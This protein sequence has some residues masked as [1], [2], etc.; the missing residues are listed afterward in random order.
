MNQDKLAAYQTLY[1]CLVTVARLMAPFAPFFS[2]RL[3]LDLTEPVRE[4]GKFASVHLE[5]FPAYDAGLAD[6]V[7]EERQRLAQVITSCVL[8]LRRKVNLKVRQPLQTLLVPVMDASQRADVEAI[9]PLLAAELNVKDVK[10]VSNEESGLVKR[11]KADFKK[12]GPKFGKIM[13]QLGKAISEME[14][15]DI[16]TL[17]KENKFTFT[18]LPGQPV[19]TLEDVE[20]F[21]EDIPGWLV[22]S[23]GSVT[24]ALDITLT[25]ELKNEGMARE[26]VNR[27]QNIR[28]SSDFEITDRV[29]VTLTDLPEVR[30]AVEQFGE[31][32]KGQVL[33]NS[34]ELASE[35]ADGILLDIDELKVTAKVERE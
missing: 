1:T 33:A 23:D 6:P 12:L 18:E 8:A 28:K 25:P 24:V 31:Y 17:E 9:V 32:I 22:G 19:V 11:V 15:K 34:L 7:L 3:W 2:D 4:E 21:P 29:K 30:A 13:K 27:I 14:Q 5:D 35:V 20:I 10:I 16:L 26:L